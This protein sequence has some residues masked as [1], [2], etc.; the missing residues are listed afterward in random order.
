MLKGKKATY[1]LL[2][3]VGSLWGLLFYKFF[4]DTSGSAPQLAKAVKG[5]YK[6]PKQKKKDTFSLLPLDRD[7]F[8]GTAYKK[9][10][11]KARVIKQIE[12]PNVL[13]KGSISGSDGRVFILSI[14]GKEYF[15]KK[16]ET[17]DGI[18]LVRGND[19]KVKLQYKGEN[20]EFKLQ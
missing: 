9:I 19:R 10:S 6:L 15:F 3:I 17:I 1:I 4:S 18:K 5:E 16:S 8:L 20:K 12:W 2:L 14:G 13:Y 7:P 11:A